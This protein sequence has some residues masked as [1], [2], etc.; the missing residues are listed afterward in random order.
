MS[1]H[2]APEG[3]EE[4]IK[5]NFPAKYRWLQR[6]GHPKVYAKVDFKA[7]YLRLSGQK[8]L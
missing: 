3:F 4:W 8:R 6:N 1:P 5:E 7:V 2:L